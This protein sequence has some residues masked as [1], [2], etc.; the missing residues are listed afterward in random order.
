MNGTGWICRLDR[1]VTSVRLWDGMYH[2]RECC[3]LLPGRIVL[4]RFDGWVGC[5]G[6]GSLNGII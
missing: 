6:C 3:K 1:L 2:D 4:I 5:W